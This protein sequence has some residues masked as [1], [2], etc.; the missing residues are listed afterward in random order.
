MKY[1]VVFTIKN[2]GVVLRELIEA[3]NAEQ[4]AQKVKAQVEQLGHKIKQIAFI[5][6][7]S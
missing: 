7:I 4:A 1:E 5:G 6:Q 2:S 3:D